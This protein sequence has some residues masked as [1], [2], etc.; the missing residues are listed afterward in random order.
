MDELKVGDK[1]VG[2]DDTVTTIKTVYD[3]HI[4]D[5]MYS[6]E[7]E[8]GEV[9]ECSGT[10]LWYTE[11]K[12]DKKNRRRYRKL[13]KAYFKNNELPELETV[14]GDSMISAYPIEIMMDKLSNDE[15]EREFIKLV[16]ESLGP[17]Y[18]T[19]MEHYDNYFEIIEEELIYSYSYND[20]IKFLTNMKLSVMNNEGYFFFGKVRSTDE[21][22]NTYEEVNI[23]RQS[24]IK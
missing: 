18:S 9:I 8:D 22:F 20:I 5:R 21:I 3:E 2:P 16:C 14:N 12:S 23:P 24:E 10:H 1:L 15:D 17:T 6:I 13:A 11:T 19:P 4:P 7:M